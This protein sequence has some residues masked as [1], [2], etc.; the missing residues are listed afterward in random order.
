MP[1]AASP[2]VQADAPE[3]AHIVHHTMGIVMGD[4]IMDMDIQR[5]VSFA[6]M[7]VAMESAI[8]ID[9]HCDRICRCEY[10]V[11]GWKRLFESP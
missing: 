9:I 8:E 11:R 1:V 3:I 10:I 6:E 2:K 5:A 4:G 7:V